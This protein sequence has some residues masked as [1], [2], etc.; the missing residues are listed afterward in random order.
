MY[1]HTHSTQIT[2]LCSELNHEQEL[3]PDTS[4]VET[5]ATFIQEM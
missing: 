5:L 4:R 2:R 1:L 3:I